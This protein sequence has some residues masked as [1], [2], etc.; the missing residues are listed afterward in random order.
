MKLSP[1][2]P[3]LALILLAVFLLVVTN[4]APSGMSL[5]RLQTAAVETF[6]WTQMARCAEDD[7]ANW[8]DG[9]P[10]LL[11]WN[12]EL[13]NAAQWQADW[14]V[15]HPE[16]WLAY[17]KDRTKPHTAHDCA[18]EPN[19]G[20]RVK[21]AGY[22]SSYVLENAAFPMLVIPGVVVQAWLNS[23]AGHREAILNPLTLDSGTGIA[24]SEQG[25]YIFVSIY[26]RI[27]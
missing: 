20:E 7:C 12:W 9:G 23:K 14:L 18:G 26:G 19:L 21:A 2:P 4:L 17:V 10:R 16:C 13:A 24:W 22:G 8:R 25:Y 15:K 6:N 27:R 1:Y 5:I 11:A 3:L